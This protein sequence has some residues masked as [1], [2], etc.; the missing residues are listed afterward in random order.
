MKKIININILLT[1]LM[2]GIFLAVIHCADRVTLM[3][4]HSF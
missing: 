3:L 4:A 2:L 1:L